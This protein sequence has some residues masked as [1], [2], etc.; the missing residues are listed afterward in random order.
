[1]EADFQLRLSPVK[2]TVL[3]RP[4]SEQVKGGGKERNII[5]WCNNSLHEIPRVSTLPFGYAAKG[6]I[7]TEYYRDGTIGAFLG[8]WGGSSCDT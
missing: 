7:R 2:S 5:I 6:K 3:R 1:M 4:E 8:H